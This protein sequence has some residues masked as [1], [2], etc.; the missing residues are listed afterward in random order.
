M[1]Y[2]VLPLLFLWAGVAAQPAGPQL[3]AG[4]TRPPPDRPLPAFRERADSYRRGVYMQTLLRD[5]AAGVMHSLIYFP[6]LDLFA[7]TTVLEIDH[8]LPP[9]AKFLH[10][11]HVPGLQVHRRHGRRPVPGR[12]RRGRSCGATSSGPTGSGR[13][14]GPRTRSSSARCSRSASPGWRSRRSGSPSSDVPASR[15]GTTSA[16][17]CRGCSATPSPPTCQHIHQVL[18]VVHVGAFFLLGGHPARHQAP[19][20]VHL[21]DEHVPLGPRPAQGRDEAAAQ[22]HRDLDGELRCERRSATSRGS[23]C[24]T[25]T[26]APSAA[27]VRACA[28]P[29]RQASRSIRARS[30]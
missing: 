18:W 3:G 6:F 16:I 10:G 30:C 28:R 19:P 14:P 27:G 12:R 4:G 11:D 22:P 9:S 29:T 1:F 26:R 20:H 24:S 25:P 2:T 7:V 8:Q 13:R 15:S 17:R 21:S 5:S 23:S